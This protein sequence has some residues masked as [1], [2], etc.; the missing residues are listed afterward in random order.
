MSSSSQTARVALCIAVV[1]TA[2]FAACPV[3]AQD[4][5]AA[6]WDDSVAP[7]WRVRGEYVYWWTNGNPL[8]PL[9]T[10]S[11]PGTPVNQAG[12]LSSPGVATLYGNQTIDTGARSGG[13][14]T[15]TRWFEEAEGP[16]I[17]FVGFYVADD[18]Q[19]GSY[20]VGSDGS[21]ILSRPF[22]NAVSG[23]EDAEL[24][25]YPNRL[26]GQ[27]TVNSYSEAYSAAGLLRHNVASD[28]WGRFDILGGYRYFR[29]RESLSVREQLLAI[30]PGGL[31]PLGT[32]TDLI[33]R[34]NVGNDF[35]GGE[36]GA[37]SE[38]IV[39][40]LSFELLAK[41][42]FGSLTRHAVVDGNTVVTVPGLGPDTTAGGLLALPTNMGSR[43]S[44]RLGILPE[45]NFNATAL[46]TPRLT[47]VG[48]YTLV[49]LNDVLRSGDQIDRT[50]NPT[51]IGNQPLQGPARPA[52]AFRD[53]TLI[54]HGFSLGLD[55]RW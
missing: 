40:T 25:S 31:T 14:V 17:E 24:V 2:A 36:I 45:L 44:T 15:L 37:A 50:L 48:G 47:F 35:H 16:A 20:A 21:R 11:P 51:Q 8:P 49:V 34:F 46:L 27:V 53:S 22:L 18:Y 52:P 26:A 28:S 5:A 7:L 19:S 13:R 32:T 9:V 3:P 30:N 39:N 54:L 1:L 6:L 4:E 55:Y 43:S 12:V 29:Y 10:T 33:D 38:W 42:A 41:V 23:Q